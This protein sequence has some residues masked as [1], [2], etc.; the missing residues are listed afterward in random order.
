MVVKGGKA[1]ENP[2]LIK[3]KS[4]W[5]ALGKGWAVEATTEA[6]VLDLYNEAA[7]KHKEIDNRP[8]Y[9]YECQAL[10]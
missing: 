4:G 5:M 3:T 6:E 8:N 2:R 9:W 1:M 7:K 10:T